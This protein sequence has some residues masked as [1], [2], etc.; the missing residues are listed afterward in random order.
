MTEVKI[1]FKSANQIREKVG[2]VIDVVG[3]NISKRKEIMW[4]WKNTYFFWV[5]DKAIIDDSGEI[6]KAELGVQ[7]AET[8]VKR[9]EKNF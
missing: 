4:D 6:M 1:H 7:R 2:I 3:K 5:I 9:S 8:G